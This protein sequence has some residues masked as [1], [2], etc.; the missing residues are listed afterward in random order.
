M[1]NSISLGLMIDLR[2]SMVAVSSIL[3][4]VVR[5]SAPDRCFSSPVSGFIKTAPHPPIPGLPEQAPSV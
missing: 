3:L 1:Y 5:F 4:L 2:D